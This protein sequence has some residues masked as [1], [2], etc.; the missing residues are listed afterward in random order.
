MRGLLGR[1]LRNLKITRTPIRIQSVEG[2]RSNYRGDTP[3][4]HRQFDETIRALFKLHQESSTRKG[5]FNNKNK[6]VKNS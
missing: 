2:A 5:K 3:E 4:E 1:M 6:T